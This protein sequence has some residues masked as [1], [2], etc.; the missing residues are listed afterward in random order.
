LPIYLAKKGIKGETKLG[1]VMSSV[2][3]EE[4]KKY[5]T[6]KKETT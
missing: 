4:K 6:K 3:S 1:F 2:F 5:Q